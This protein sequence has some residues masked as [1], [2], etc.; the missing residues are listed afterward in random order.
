MILISKEELAQ[1]EKNSGQTMGFSFKEDLDFIKAKEGQE[2]IKKIE[3]AL[4]GLGYPLKYEEIRSYHWYP[5]KQNLL[6]LVLAQKI[7]KWDDQS[8]RELGRFDAKVSFMAKL[9]MKFFV[10][11]EQLLKEASN[12]WR[13]Y[14]SQGRLEIETFD[15]KRHLV[16][17]SV[18]DFLGHPVFCRELEGF[19]GKPP[20]MSS[21][22]KILKFKK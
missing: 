4:K 11:L 15:K 19:F 9:M 18:E 17:I 1:I 16:I 20:P 13:R 6:V 7:F 14:F 3:A 5:W 21:Q 2:G 22:K 12:Y 10:S 8:Y